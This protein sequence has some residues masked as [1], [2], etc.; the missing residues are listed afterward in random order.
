MATS[1]REPCWPRS[2]NAEKRDEN[3]RVLIDLP[4]ELAGSQYQPWHAE[5]R[6]LLRRGARVLTRTGMGQTE[7]NSV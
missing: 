4:S 5:M 1:G 3:S 2:G 7:K 6:R